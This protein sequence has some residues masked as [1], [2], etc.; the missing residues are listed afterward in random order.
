M[1]FLNENMVEPEE[2]E[3][4]VVQSFAENIEKMLM[5]EKM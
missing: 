3:G 4:I 2:N 1:C 5:F